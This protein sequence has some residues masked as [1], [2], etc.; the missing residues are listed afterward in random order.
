MKVSILVPIYGVE[1]YIEQCAIS[2]FEQT[3]KD[4]EYIFVDDCSTDASIQKLESLLSIYPHKKPYVKFVRHDRNRGLGASR[5]TALAASTGDYIFNVDSDDYIPLN[6]VEKLVEVQ[7]RTDADIVS[8]AFQYLTTEG[9]FIEKQPYLLDKVHTLKLLLT[10]NTILNNIWGRLIRKSLYTDNNIDSIEGVN[11]AEDYGLTTRL[12]CAAKNIAYTNDIVYIYRQ[13]SASSTFGEIMN[14]RHVISILKANDAVIRF[15]Q[16]YDKEKEYLFAMETGMLNTYYMGIT[17]GFSKKQIS[18]ICFYEPNSV[19]F[20]LMHLLFAN[21]P[22]K[23]LLRLSYLT[24][25]WFYKRK[26]H[27]PY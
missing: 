20:K 22:A 10:Q 11:M 5:K 9:I 12:V 7:R 4:I 17:A 3:Y 16:T 2:L 23:K 21:K 25:K 1:Q 13:G 15:V 27:F 24:T 18:D 26:L 19:L 14:P 6:A 8:G